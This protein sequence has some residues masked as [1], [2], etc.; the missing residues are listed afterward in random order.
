MEEPNVVLVRQ[1]AWYS[2]SGDQEIRR[3]NDP[4]RPQ[5]Q[6]EEDTVNAALYAYVLTALL[7][8][9]VCW[10]FTRG[11]YRGRM[12]QEQKRLIVQLQAVSVGCSACHRPGRSAA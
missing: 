8:A 7:A 12:Q 4:F 3:F 2:D 10:L 9:L 11:Y 1:C 6:D 5:A